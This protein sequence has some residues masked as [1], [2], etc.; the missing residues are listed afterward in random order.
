M[1]FV[2]DKPI[3]RFK[4]IALPIGQSESGLVERRRT[5]I[6]RARFK[7]ETPDGKKFIVGYDDAP[8]EKVSKQGWAD[9]FEDAFLIAMER[10]LDDHE[11]G[12]MD[13]HECAVRIMAVNETVIEMVGFQTSQ[14]VDEMEAAVLESIADAK[15]D[16]DEDDVIEKQ[17]D[18]EE[19]EDDDEPQDFEDD[20]DD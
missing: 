8:D 9:N 7:G 5:H 20:D 10:L 17:R 2:I 18:D 15:D 19:E 14:N 13:T 16:D 11:Q 1:A 6:D 4:Y 3:Y 12:A